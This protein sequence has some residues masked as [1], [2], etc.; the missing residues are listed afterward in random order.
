MGSDTKSA[1]APAPR[2]LARIDYFK[3]HAIDESS[4]TQFGG[5]LTILI[6]LA[7]AAYI[8][9]AAVIFTQ[10]PPVTTT[11]AAIYAGSCTFITTLTVF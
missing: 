5:C 10:A 6:P 2:L 7:V 4:R 1:D 9:V 3:E 8:A 11:D